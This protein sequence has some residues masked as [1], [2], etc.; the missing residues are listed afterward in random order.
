MKTS[1]VGFSLVDRLNIIIF[2]TQVLAYIFQA[3]IYHG[4]SALMNVVL[5]H[6]AKQGMDCL[7]TDEVWDGVYRL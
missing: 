5:I 1:N 6:S 2:F 4:I 7:M 3:H